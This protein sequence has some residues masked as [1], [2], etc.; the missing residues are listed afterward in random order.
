MLYTSAERFISQLES[1][2][3]DDLHPLLRVEIDADRYM[4]LDLSVFNHDL[5]KVD[6]SS[7]HEIQAYID[8]KLVENDAH[9]AYGGYLEERAIYRR[10]DYFSIPSDPNKERNIH[11]GLDL[12]CDAGTAV[13]TPLD[14][15]VHSFADNQEYGDYGPTIILEHELD[16]ARFYTLYGHLSRASIVSLEVGQLF[17]KGEKLAELGAPEVN[18]DYAPH[19]HFQLITDMEDYWGDFP[20][21]CSKEDL[22]KFKEICPNPSIFVL[23]N[24]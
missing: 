9:V 20:G 13:Y 14:G 7:A 4:K 2:D 23:K 21:V 10:S 17:D 8:R 12:W 15:K 18:G 6:V 16:G 19:L 3:K 22:E 5:E 1:L 11:L 24:R